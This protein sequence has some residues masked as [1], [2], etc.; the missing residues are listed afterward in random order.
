MAWLD[1]SEIA[2][3]LGQRAETVCRRYLDAGRRCGNYWQVGDVRN[4]QGRSMFMRLEDSSRAPAGRWRDAATGE[5]GDLLDV[6]RESRSLSSFGE[7]LDEARLFLSLPQKDPSRAAACSRPCSSH[8]DLQEAARRL[9]IMSRP[10]TGTLA[11]RYLRNRGVT[12]LTDLL[13]LRFH[14]ECRWRA[15]ARSPPEE[16]P[17]MIAAVTDLAGRLTGVQRSW[18]DPQGF[19]ETTFGKAP[20]EPPRKAMG[21][22]YGHAVRFGAPGEVMAV[23]EGVETVLSLH[24]ALPAM[25]M[26]AA[27]SA[28][29]LAATHIPERV[30]RLYIA[31]DRDP[32]GERAAMT[33]AERVAEGGVEAIILAPRYGD[34]NDDLLLHGVEDLRNA[35]RRQLF[36]RDA[37]R[38]LAP[39]R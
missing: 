8:L 34:F 23:G 11:E 21:E 14:A 19:S 20:I 31:Q 25:P 29:N 1:P 6:I 26:A 28:T 33:L 36:S 4:S 3:R 37:T 12:A 35:L 7:V 10:I 18:L 22:L 15:D 30:R 9:F 39:A 32:A 2:Y 5:F 17:A 38:F 27:L 13:A 16:R 24:S